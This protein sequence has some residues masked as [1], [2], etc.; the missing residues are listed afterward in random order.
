VKRK[1]PK[2]KIQPWPNSTFA[3]KT[4]WEDWGTEAHFWVHLE[5]R[6][7]GKFGRMQVMHAIVIRRRRPSADDAFFGSA[8]YRRG[9]LEGARK[10]FLQ[11]GVPDGQAQDFMAAIVKE[12]PYPSDEDLFA[13]QIGSPL[14]ALALGER[15]KDLSYYRTGVPKLT[16]EDVE[17]YA[18]CMK[19]LEARMKEGPEREKFLEAFKRGLMSILFT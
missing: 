7:P 17:L 15:R 11:A 3:I 14:V 16:K 4:K 18:E 10:A 6:A 13:E 5:R 9:T 8:R 12:Y 2:P 19:Q 1:E